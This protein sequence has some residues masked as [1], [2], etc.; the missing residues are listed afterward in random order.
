MRDPVNTLA[1]LARRSRGTIVRLPAGST[2]VYLVSH[3][4]HVQHVLRG[5]W[6]NYQRQGMFWR[7]LRRLLGASI[8][9]DGAAWEASRGILQPLLTARKVGSLGEEMA[10]AIDERVGELE[11]HAASGR[12]FD[13]GEELADLVNQTVIKVL[14]GGRL[15]PEDGRRLSPAYDKAARAVALR[16]FLPSLSY[17]MRLPGDRAYQEA[18]ETIDEVVLPMIRRRHP[19]PGGDVL[20]ALCHARRERGEGERQIRDD[21]VSVY[22]AAAESTATTLTWLWPALDRRPDVAAKLYAEVDRVVGAGPVRAGHLPELTYTSMVLREL[23][24]LWPSG[25]LFPRMAEKADRVGGV[26]VEAGAQVLITPYA[27]HRLDEFWERPLEF[28]PERF[29]PGAQERRHRY[30][31]FP[32]GG[33]P[34]LCLGRPLFEMAAPLIIAAVLSRFRPILRGGGPFTPFPAGSLRP[35]RKVELVLVRA[36]RGAA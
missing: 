3:P 19:R 23:M 35:R 26:A 10:R 28:D 36:R 31:Y 30:A 27:T 32:F 4:D 2:P 8:L 24:R 7:P 20:S 29:A 21:V 33:G 16:M 1:A 5:N 11:V 18:I 14:F 12:A 17:S 22:G 15:S 34:H 6:E 25:W 9:D 13:A